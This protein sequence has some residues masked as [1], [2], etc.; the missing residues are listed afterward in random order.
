MLIRGIEPTDMRSVLAEQIGRLH[1]LSLH[2]H[3]RGAGTRHAL[4]MDLHPRKTKHGDRRDDPDAEI[5]SS[6]DSTEAPL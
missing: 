2:Q 4:A 3:R 5:E 6:L 1:W